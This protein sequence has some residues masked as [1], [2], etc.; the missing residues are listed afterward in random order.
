[1]AKRKLSAAQRKARKH[2]AYIRSEYYKN[3]D[4]L[5]YLKDFTKIKDVKIPNKITKRSL[6]S[7]RR[8]YKEARKA[9]QKVDGY[10]LDKTTGELKEK[11]P[12]KEEMVKEVRQE[13]T[14]QYRQ[15]RAEPKEDTTFDPDM[16][17]I[18]SVRDAIDAM[19]PRD[20]EDPKKAS[21]VRK[22]EEARLR[23]YGTL[24]FALQ[25][26]DVSSLAQALASNDYVQRVMGVDNQY[27]YEIEEAIDN[28]LIPLL[29]A[30]MNNALDEYL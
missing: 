15:N 23:L 26:T 16:Q 29:E 6:E 2:A 3:F 14:Q 24:D 8:I 22:F 12:T 10:F 30:S 21:T 4:A 25:K 7:I 27:A 17:Y 18:D 19:I 5:Q 9:I 20:A 1:M 13:P 28:D 11:L